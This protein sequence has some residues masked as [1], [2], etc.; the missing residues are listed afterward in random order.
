MTITGQLRLSFIIHIDIASIYSRK[1]YHYSYRNSGRTNKNMCVLKENVHTSSE[2]P[3]FTVYT[4]S[5]KKGCVIWG[6]QSLD[7]DMMPR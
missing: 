1:I 7:D 6:N 4:F 2:S 3:G 5:G